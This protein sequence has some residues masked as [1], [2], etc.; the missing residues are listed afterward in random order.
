MPPLPLNDSPTGVSVLVNLS[1][2]GGSGLTGLTQGSVA[3][4]FLL[5]RMYY[6]RGFENLMV[7]T[8]QSAGVVAVP[9]WQFEP[10]VLA[11]GDWPG[12][13][14]PESHGA[15]EHPPIATNWNESPPK[16]AWKRRVGP[17]WS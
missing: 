14:G 3:H 10:L 7:S 15:Q 1:A 11:A 2:G 5:M 13:R 4:G 9:G 16:L 6:L 12:F 17:A 8:L